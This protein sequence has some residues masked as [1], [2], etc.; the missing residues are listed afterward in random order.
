MILKVETDHITDGL[1]QLRD[2][3]DI[4]NELQESLNEY[5]K[6][7]TE[8]EVPA[9]EQEFIEELIDELDKWFEIDENAYCFNIE[10]PS[11]Y[12]TGYNVLQARNSVTQLCEAI[13]ALHHQLKT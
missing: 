8:K 3:Y 13:D 2:C 12:S 4:S 11:F 10:N 1:E 7:L 6:L 9:L 5:N